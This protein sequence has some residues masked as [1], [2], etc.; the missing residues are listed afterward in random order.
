MPKAIVAFSGGV[1]STLLLLVAKEVL[2]DSVVAVH[3]RSPFGS[4]QDSDDCRAFADSIGC[5]YR[6]ILLDELESQDIQRNTTRRCYFCKQL[7]MGRI[8]ALAETEGVPWIL[9]GSN[10]DDLGDYRP[11]ME[12]M[13]EISIA[14]SPLIEAG[15]TKQDVRDALRQKGLT[16]WDKPAAACLASRIP[17]DMPIDR[18]VL[19]QIDQAE[20]AIRR[21]LEPNCQLRV[22]HHG[23]LARIELDERGLQ[24]LLSHRLSVVSSL[25]KV[26]YRYVTLDLA[27]YQ[28]SGLHY[29]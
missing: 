7:R 8:Q 3:V 20:R 22:R 10:I 25:K 9:D 18:T 24:L 12:A 19:K 26:G 23:D 16:C 4:D 2:L 13:K 27:L 15:F 17:Y 29:N 6:E 14:R 11:G 28:M 21:F 5:S 1:D